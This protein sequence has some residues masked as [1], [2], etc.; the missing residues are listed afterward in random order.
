MK[1]GNRVGE[2]EAEKERKRGNDNYEPNVEKK[3]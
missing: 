3:Q 1:R 2:R